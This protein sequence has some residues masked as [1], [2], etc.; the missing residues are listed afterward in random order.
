MAFVPDI[1]SRIPVWMAMSELFLDT[2]LTE[3]DWIRI[4]DTLAAS[5]YS[6]RELEGI[7]QDEVA[8]VCEANLRSGAGEWSGFNQAWLVGQLT[9]LLE[10]RSQRFGRGLQGSVAWDAW[11]SVRDRITAMRG[12]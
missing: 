3:S 10:Q 7:L 5:G 9:A 2:E 4:A 6:I 12:S 1:E 11:K 8:A